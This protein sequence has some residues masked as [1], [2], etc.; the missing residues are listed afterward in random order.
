MN[1]TSANQLIERL[2]ADTTLVK[3]LRS[4][5]LRTISWLLL[6][7]PWVVAV[8]AIMGLRSDLGERVTD[9]RWMVEQIATFATALAAAMAAFCAGVPGRPRW[10][11]F[12]P[13]LPLAIWLG[14]LGDGCLQS[15]HSLGSA[16][17]TLHTD[18]LCLP[19]IMMA[20]FAPAIAMTVMILRGSAIAPMTTTA[21][22]ALAAGGLA[23]FGLRLFHPEDASVMVLIWQVGT[24]FAMVTIA[25][26]LGRTV[27]RW[28]PALLASGTAA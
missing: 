27:L 10:E 26:L 21:L 7:A 15:W 23:E 11:R 12:V 5:L 1:D 19:A 3:P 4:P 25:G 22:G 20:S 9:F 17:L 14:S 18:W 6:S 24:V 13:L 8:V 2:A 16:G 28:R